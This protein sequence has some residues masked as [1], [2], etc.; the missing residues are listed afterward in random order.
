MALKN[1]RK[2]RLVDL[3]FL[4]LSFYN[5]AARLLNSLDLRLKLKNFK[6]VFLDTGT[7]NFF[8]NVR[9]TTE[10]ALIYHS[11][12]GYLCYLILREKE[13]TKPHSN[14]SF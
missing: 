14:T 7:L 10:R 5:K 9:I 8:L 2:F 13:K 11:T 1:F 4:G 6:P 3:K 12:H